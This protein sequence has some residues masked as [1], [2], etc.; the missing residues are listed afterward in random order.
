[1]VAVWQRPVAEPLNKL[2]ES[3]RNEGMHS[4]STQQKCSWRW[5]GFR[6]PTVWV[7]IDELTLSYKNSDVNTTE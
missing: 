2:L 4:Q 5:W 6:Q 3:S 7:A 1:M